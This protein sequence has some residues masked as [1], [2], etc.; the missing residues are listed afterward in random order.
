MCGVSLFREERQQSKRN[1]K[2]RHKEKSARSFRQKYYI[3]HFC[4]SALLHS[5]PSRSVVTPDFVP[6]SPS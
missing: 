5:T 2:E 1:E 4:A 3:S 6:D